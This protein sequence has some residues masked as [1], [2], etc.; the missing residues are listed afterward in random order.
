MLSC[1]YYKI[2]KVIYFEDHLWTTAYEYNSLEI[3]NT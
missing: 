2:F 1:E 3:K